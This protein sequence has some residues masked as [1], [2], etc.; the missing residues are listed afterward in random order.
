MPESV[1]R[2]LR[3]AEQTLAM[4][5]HSPRLDA[6]LLLAHSLDWPRSRLYARSDEQLSAPAKQQFLELLAARSQGRP[7]AYLL[8]RQE[9][10]SLTFEV[11]E[12]CLVPRPETEA[13]VELALQHHDNDCRV[14]DLGTGSGA[15]AVAIA[16]ERPHWQVTAVDASDRALHWA[17]RNAEQHGVRLELLQG[18]WF[19]PLGERRFDIILS[20]PPYVAA[21]DPHLA[22][23]RFEPAEALSAGDDGLADLRRIVAAAPS[24]LHPGGLLAMEHGHAQ[25]PAVRQLLQAAGFTS[26]VTAPDLT[27]LERISHGRL[28]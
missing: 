9:F 21:R 11:G 7:V 8:G 28:P 14:L 2:H 25:G 24:H 20:N 19:A 15:I 26:V 5:S 16:H 10:W 4:V 1:R 22:D 27:G 12:G 13:L 18:D 6:E 3:E 23:L 17:Q